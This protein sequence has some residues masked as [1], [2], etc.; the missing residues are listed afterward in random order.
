MLRTRQGWRRQ[1][2]DGT[3]VLDHHTE[4]C[5]LHWR[6]S[7]GPSSALRTQSQWRLAWERWGNVILPKC[8]DQRPGTRP[9]ALYA[10][11]LIPPPPMQQPLPRNHRFLTVYVDGE[12]G[13]GVTHVIAREPYQRSE[14]LHLRDLGIV[15]DDEYRRH[16]AWRAGRLEVDYLFEVASFA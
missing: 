15:D 9:A 2:S 16:R 14:V 5:L 6:S 1:Y 13:T 7:L 10:L 11:G 12:D 4:S 8:L 3:E